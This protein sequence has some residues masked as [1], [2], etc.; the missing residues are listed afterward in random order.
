MLYKVGW[1]EL[2]I[3]LL[4]TVFS[5]GKVIIVELMKILTEPRSQ[6][7]KINWISTFFIWSTTIKFAMLFMT[8][9][10]YLHIIKSIIEHFLVTL[11][12]GNPG[13]TTKVVILKKNSPKSVLKRIQKWI[14]ESSIWPAKVKKLEFKVKHGIKKKTLSHS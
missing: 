8:L 2:L 4:E 6:H 7:I 5:I 12:I 14:V 3:N 1:D 11:G 9:Q 13:H 10:K